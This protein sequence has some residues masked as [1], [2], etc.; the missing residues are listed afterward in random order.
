MW[1]QK[2]SI[3]HPQKG[4]EFPGDGGSVRSKNLRDILV[5]LT[6]SAGEQLVFADW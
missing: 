4:L 3:L 6:I 1:V 2:V 5:S